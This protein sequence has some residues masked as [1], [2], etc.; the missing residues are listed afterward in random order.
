MPDDSPDTEDELFRRLTDRANP[1]TPLHFKL[2]D[3]Q[4]A[5]AA[6]FVRADARCVFH[7]TEGYTVGM[8]AASPKPLSK[9][10]GPAEDGDE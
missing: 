2:L 6:P 5:R 10:L 3:R 7:R 8:T 4:V 1:R 9:M